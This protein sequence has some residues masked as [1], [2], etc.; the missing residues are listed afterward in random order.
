MIS[1]NK[2]QKALKQVSFYHD[3]KIKN[4]AL[5]KIKKNRIKQMKMRIYPKIS[6]IMNRK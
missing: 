2:L 3:K 5:N 6:R 1:V 4:A